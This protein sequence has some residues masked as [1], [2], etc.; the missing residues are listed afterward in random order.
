MFI[1]PAYIAGYTLAPQVSIEVAIGGREREEAPELDSIHPKGE[2][3]GPNGNNA[4]YIQPPCLNPLLGL[5]LSHS[6]VH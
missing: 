2:R 4:R 5:S 1:T 6:E 3:K